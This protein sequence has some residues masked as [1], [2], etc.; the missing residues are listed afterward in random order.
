MRDGLFTAKSGSWQNP[1]LKI[2]EMSLPVL[3]SPPR[4]CRPS[5]AV[6]HSK[7]KFTL[8]AGNLNVRTG[9]IIH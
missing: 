6:K 1:G 3:D 4:V 8:L 9:T 7:R 2:S 5:N